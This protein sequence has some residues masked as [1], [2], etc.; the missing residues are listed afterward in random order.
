MEII[1][2][3]KNHLENLQLFIQNIGESRNSFRYFEKRDISVVHNHL[4]TF[5]LMNDNM[6]IGYGHLE[7]DDAVVWL[8]I[9]ILPDF[10]GR[11]LGKLMMR[12]LLEEGRQ[13][14]LDSITL[15]VDKENLNAIKLYESFGFTLITDESHYLK[16]KIDLV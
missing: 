7:K 1:K 4:A 14:N 6:A 13:L 3:K 5:L 9:C 15:T 10:K 11:G 8:G 12:A 2:V 16:Y